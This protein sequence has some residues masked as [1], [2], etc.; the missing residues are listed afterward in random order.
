MCKLLISGT[1][2]LNTNSFIQCKFITDVRDFIF[3]SVYLFHIYI[4]IYIYI[5]IYMC[6]CVNNGLSSD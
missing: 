4:C 2:G 5:Y 3:V 6:V 1:I